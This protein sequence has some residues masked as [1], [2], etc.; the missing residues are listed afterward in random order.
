MSSL[1]KSKVAIAVIQEADAT[2]KHP[3][4]TRDGEVN[5]LVDMLLHGW[6]DLEEEEREEYLTE[7]RLA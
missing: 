1:E 6:D 4:M 3:V 2:N 5:F 7:A